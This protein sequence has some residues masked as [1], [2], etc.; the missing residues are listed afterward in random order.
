MKKKILL[1]ISSLFM[2]SGCNHYSGTQKFD[3]VHIVSQNKCYEIKS[4]EYS[5]SSVK[6]L[7]KGGPTI[8]ASTLEAIL[9]SGEC[10]YCNKK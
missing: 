9:I 3:T 5:G 2:L 1:A 6:V 4:W 10:I 7:I 8:L